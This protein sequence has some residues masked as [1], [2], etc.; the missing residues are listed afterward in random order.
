VAV[1]MPAAGGSAGQTRR[2]GRGAST[3]Q[4]GTHANLAL[5]PCKRREKKGCAAPSRGAARTSPARASVRRCREA[6]RMAAL[7]AGGAA[8]RHAALPTVASSGAAG[9]VDTVVA[10]AAAGRQRPRTS[11]PSSHHKYARSRGVSAPTRAFCAASA[12]RI[13]APWP[14]PLHRLSW[15]ATCASCS[16]GPRWWRSSGWPSSRWASW[17]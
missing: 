4:E 9:V 5:G 12:R 17:A 15:R 7:M 6:C 16:A 11:P 8:M 1:A 3:H 13:R 10:G 14:A 2:A